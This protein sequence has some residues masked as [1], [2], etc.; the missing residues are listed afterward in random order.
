MYGMLGSPCSKKGGDFSSGAPPPTG[1][2]TFLRGRRR[3]SFLNIYF[4]S[5]KVVQM[6][7]KR[8]APCYGY[9]RLALGKSTEPL[10]KDSNR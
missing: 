2:R 10:R 1:R 5:F 7:V 3:N 9:I 4:Y 6:K 8:S